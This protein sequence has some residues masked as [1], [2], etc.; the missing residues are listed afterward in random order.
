MVLDED[1]QQARDPMVYDV[2]RD[3]ATWLGGE[4]VARERAA[5]SEKEG[6]HWFAMR[7]R[8]KGR[9]VGEG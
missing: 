8:L 1:L 5:E 3:T 7:A 4:Y 9:S 6:A 2:M